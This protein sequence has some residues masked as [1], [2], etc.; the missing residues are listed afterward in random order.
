LPLSATGVQTNDEIQP[1]LVCTEVKLAQGYANDAKQIFQR[2]RLA[3]QRDPVV[4]EEVEYDFMYFAGLFGDERALA[5]LSCSNKPSMEVL[6]LLADNSAERGDYES[7]IE[8]LSRLDEVPAVLIKIFDFLERSNLLDKET[9]MQNIV[10]KLESQFPTAACTWHAKI[11]LPSALCN[12]AAIGYFRKLL[13]CFDFHKYVGSS[14]ARLSR[15]DRDELRELYTMAVLAASKI[16]DQST[17]ELI[18]L[19]LHGEKFQEC[20]ERMKILSLDVSTMERLFDRNHS[21]AS[22]Y[23]EVIN[24]AASAYLKG[25]LQHIQRACSYFE[26]LLSF[27]HTNYS[28]FFEFD[29]SWVVFHH[30]GWSLIQLGKVEMGLEVYRRGTR[31]LLHNAMIYFNYALVLEN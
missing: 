15:I 29:D 16:V 8:Y 23:C 9:R 21:L 18:I 4:L 27:A 28:D 11:M 26:K 31:I 1:L 7:A 24:A 14:F 19:H 6:G 12:P 3:F 5:K 30:Y 10:S 17:L 13:E 22:F 20:D 2:A 25:G